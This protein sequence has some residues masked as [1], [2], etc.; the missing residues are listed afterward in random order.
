MCVLEA[1]GAST[2]IGTD[3]DDDDDGH[4][5]DD[6]GD[7]DDDDLALSC[8]QTNES[9]YLQWIPLIERTELNFPAPKL[10]PLR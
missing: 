3:D 1:L 4:G 8:S 9:N 5:H 2:A 6:G 7:D 10:E